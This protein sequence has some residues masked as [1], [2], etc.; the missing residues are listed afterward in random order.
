[1]TGYRCRTLVTMDGAVLENAMFLVA[2]KEFLEIG[3]A[4]YLESKYL[5]PTVDLGEVVVLPG[6]INAHCHLDYSLM[7]GALL[8]SHSFAQWVSRINALKRNLTDDDYLRATSLG[9]EELE[10]TGVTTVLNIVAAPQIM[11]HLAPPRI[12]SWFF[13]ELIDV[14]PRPWLDQY[15]FGSWLFFE[16][17]EGWVGGF[18]LS[19]HAPYTVSE[20]LFQLTQACSHAFGLPVTTHVSE[21]REEYEMFVDGAGRL[22]EFLAKLGRPMR[23]CGRSSPLRSL[24]ERRLISNETIVVHLNEL[25]AADLELL[26]QPEWRC[27]P[28]V[29]CPKSHRFLHHRPFP[30]EH[31]RAAGCEISLGTDS[32]A[33]N[34]SLDLF[35]EMRAARSNFNSLPPEELLRMCTVYPARA[36]RQ[37]ARL[38]KIA[39]GYLADAIA[40][41]FS[42]WVEEV[43]EAIVENRDPVP[44]MMVDGKVLA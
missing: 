21:S 7:R 41:P 29:H 6:L 3:S 12:R 11:P 9:L 2:D 32:L 1:M 36:I 33:S 26:S 8:P 4:E 20:S 19:P 14:R 13:L 40:L 24:V 18:G 27:L 39:R 5:C 22:F 31:L 38:G 35:A 16:R 10:R 25:D 17:P 37:G 43:Y 34:D 28:I 15:A 30:L 42:G 23:D 44:W